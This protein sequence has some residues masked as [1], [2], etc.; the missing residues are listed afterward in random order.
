MRAPL[1]TDENDR[2]AALH[3]T[4]VLDTLPE[5]DFDDIALL[6]SEICGTPMGLVSLV[7]TDRQWFKAKVGLEVDEMHRDMSF[8]AH[9]VTGHDLFEVPD[10]LADARFADNPLVLG[11]DNVRFYAG[12]PVVLDGT[13]SVGTVCVV[14]HVPR[15]L[16]TGQRRALRSLARHAS[17]QLEL[18]R[19]ARHAGDIADRMRQL[20]RMKDSFLA[21]V[22]HELRTPLASIR[23][24]LEM[25]LE[26]DFDPDT[27]QR[28]L[29]VMQRN[30]DRLLRLID[31]L[32]SVA[33]LNGE[34][35]DLDVV[36]LDLAELAHQVTTSCR[37]LAEH[38]EITLLNSTERPILARGDARRLGQAL[39]HLIVNAIKFTSPGGEIT[40]CGTEGDE[41]EIIIRDTGVGIPA[42]ELPH[43][44]DRFFRSAAADQMAVQGPG[45]GLSIVRLIIDAHHGS[46]HVDSEPGIGTAIRLTLPKP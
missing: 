11:D 45:L 6:A 5:D 42:A 14:D 23:G 32:L 43:L 37:P 26:D 24:Y 28:F 27:S 9:A 7:D 30:S 33:R 46:I 16:S 17:V 19:Y 20:D 8:C 34:G 25:L 15:E 2:V 44:F 18:R 4:R 10:A 40:I 12:A 41:P 31:D 38:R 1:P 22:S 3:D 36:E 29:S 13:H 35:V 21:G 39:N